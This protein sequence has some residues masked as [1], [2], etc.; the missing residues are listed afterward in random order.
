MDPPET[1][2]FLKPLFKGEE[3]YSMNFMIWQ[4]RG[5]VSIKAVNGP[6]AATKQLPAR[7]MQDAM[8]N[9]SGILLNHIF[10]EGLDISAHIVSPSL[11]PDRPLLQV[12]FHSSN[13]N[14]EL[15]KNISKQGNSRKDLKQQP[16]QTKWCLLVHAEKAG[17]ELIGS[18]TI[19]SRES[20]CI[21]EIKVPLSWWDSYQTQTIGVYFAINPWSETLSTCLV[22]NVTRYDIEHEH[23]KSMTSTVTLTTGQLTYSELK[24]DQHILVY[25][26]RRSFY[27]G[28]VVRVPVKLQ[29][30]SDLRTFVV[31]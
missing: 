7:L 6:F 28:S 22:N 21:A 10:I 1:G 3:M 19:D 16:A 31:R 24:E 30:D 26:P 23:V 12:L 18:C 5:Q 15:V 25:V 27:L 13:L 20:V 8:N 11:T 9:Q 2:F 14:S 29:T 4:P 17:K